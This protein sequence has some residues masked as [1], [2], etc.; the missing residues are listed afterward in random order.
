[1]QDDIYIIYKFIYFCL[2]YILYTYNAYTHVCVF[3]NYLV[4]EIVKKLPRHRDKQ[5][6]TATELVL[7]SV[8]DFQLESY[9]M[10]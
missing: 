1:M 10:L 5:D 6:R 3:F 7:L 8:Q 9:S 4:E 2:L